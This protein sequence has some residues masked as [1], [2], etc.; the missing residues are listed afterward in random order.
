M[1]DEGRLIAG[2]YRLSQRI[3]SGAMGVVWRAEDERLHRT[4]AVKQLV[5]QPGL[6]ETE[7]NEAIQRAMREGRIAARLHHPNAIT[8][9]DVVEENGAPCLVMEYL[10]SRSLA[11]V[12]AERGPLPPTE[13][14]RIGS[15]VAAALA[16]AHTAGII[17][18]DIKPGNILLGDDGTVKITDFGISR[19]SGDVTV[20]KTGM[21]AG[22]PAYLA[23]EVACGK[24]P[25]PASDVFSL[26]STLY[27][28]VEG[29]PPFG[30][31]ENTLALLH[32]VATGRVQPPQQA[33]PLTP[34]LARLLAADP[35]DR[36]TMAEAQELLE[37][38]ASGG[39]VPDVVGAEAEPTRVVTKA[40]RAESD[41]E[42][43]QVV[44]RRS[45]AGAKAGTASRK[46]VRPTRSGKQAAVAAVDAPPE[47][48]RGSR[49]LV[50]SGVAV[51]VVGALGILLLSTNLSSPPPSEDSTTP[52]HSTQG[53]TTAEQVL[54]VEL[55]SKQ[56]VEP[57]DT[58]PDAVPT[59][60]HTQ[61]TGQVEPT[62]TATEHPEPGDPGHVTSSTT[63]SSPS[64]TTTP[65]SSEPPTTTTATT[66]SE[67]T[68]SS[69]NNGAS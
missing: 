3:G 52:V 1:S 65:P 34:V 68:A 40:K 35:A 43:T 6:S 15:H 30:L 64:R 37:V 25:S 27:A 67:N 53:S 18:R 60:Q 23:P 57:T 56:E 42:P 10:P 26:G 31:N 44:T 14:A 45:A 62:T 33:G 24:D 28:A 54:P 61:S 49:P 58:V 29:R 5:L 12:M 20:T 22:T 4:V 50:L 36:P 17:H 8:V 55:T 13:V 16:A 59:A 2:R 69:G 11:A 21:V 39:T 48:Q 41:A 32:A 38:V 19:A 47:E 7:S 63:K 46:N 51:A 9:F 66:T